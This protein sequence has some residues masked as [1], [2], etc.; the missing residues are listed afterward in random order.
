VAPDLAVQFDLSRSIRTYQTV[1]L[2]DLDA[3]LNGNLDV[4]HNLVDR[5]V[6]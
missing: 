6:V 3:P 1:T 5:V 2:D 4:S